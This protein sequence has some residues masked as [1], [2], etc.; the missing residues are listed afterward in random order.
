MNVNEEGMNEKEVRL[1]RMVGTGRKKREWAGLLLEGVFFS[2]DWV[3]NAVF[4]EVE[5]VFFYL[6]TR[7]PHHRFDRN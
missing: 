1:I 7:A 2:V 5:F 4:L 3:I 6:A